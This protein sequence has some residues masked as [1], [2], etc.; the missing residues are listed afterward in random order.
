MCIAK[1]V[2]FGFK[3]LVYESFMISYQQI[4]ESCQKFVSKVNQQCLHEWA[5]D[6]E[7]YFLFKKINK[8]DQKWHKF[9]GNLI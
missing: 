4:T 1:H 3:A 9:S 5:C 7:F 2:K 6:I 8:T